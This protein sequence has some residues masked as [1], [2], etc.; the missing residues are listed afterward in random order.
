MSNGADDIYT[1]TLFVGLTRPATIWGIPYTAAIIEIMV[2]ALIFL[3]VGN[4]IYIALIVPLHATL[5]LISATDPGAF[6]S[7]YM[8]L[9]TIG[10]CRNTRFWGAA[11]F[12]PLSTKKWTK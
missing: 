11:S 2:T 8:W 4:P 6:E 1:D 5:Y 12:S 3:A 7:I 10:R 9:K